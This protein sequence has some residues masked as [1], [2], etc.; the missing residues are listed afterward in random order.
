MGLSSSCCEQEAEATS[1]PKEVVEAT[2]ACKEPPS[3][4]LEKACP[5]EVEAE[6]GDLQIA[7]SKPATTRSRILQMPHF[8]VDPE[9]LRGIELRQS[10]RRFGKLWRESPLDLQIQERAGL[11]ERSKPVQSYDVFLSHTWLTPGRWKVLALVIQCG[12]KQIILVWC[13]CISVLGIIVVV[14]EPPMPFRYISG[15]LG[16]TTPCPFGPWM[17]SGSFVAMMLG[18]ALVPYTPAIC[19][20]SSVCFLD[21][22]CIHQTD[23][24]LM[25]RGVYGLGGF[26][27]QSAELKVLWSPP[28]LT[29]LWC[30]FELAAYHAANP[31]G[32]VTLSPVFVE[33]G[34]LIMVVGSH[35]ASAISEVIFVSSVFGDGVTI[36]EYDFVA[37]LGGLLPVFI[38]IHLLRKVI[39]DRHHMIASLQTFAVSDAQCR[40]DFDREF[41]QNAICAW[42][43]SEKAFEDFVRHSLREEL[44]GI[45]CTSRI[46][47]HYIPLVA[48]PVVASTFDCITSMVIGRAPAEVVLTHFLG[49]SLAQSFFWFFPSLSLIIYLCDRWAF[50]VR[51]GWD[52]ATTFLIFLAFYA[53]FVG[54]QTITNLA[55]SHS[56]WTTLVWFIFTIFVTACLVLKRSFAGKS[57]AIEKVEVSH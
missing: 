14:V 22:A 42:Y 13:I 2:H 25:A 54:G 49:F 18:L 52:H 51:E 7:V 43:G 8:D 53:A 29:R 48:A 45:A 17:L 47:W 4:E 36:S 57:Q 40:S 12:W 44:M 33:T 19:Q 20:K 37:Y 1:A 16:F 30:V 41:I 38:I 35:M 21:V 27:R 3:P 31:A 26:L 32:K 55:C 6:D 50:P 9:L 39:R 56:F 11:W 46:P 34:L 15:T 10:L 24:D 5:G 23:E 28:Y